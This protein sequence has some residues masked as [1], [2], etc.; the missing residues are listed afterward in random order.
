MLLEASLSF[1]GLGVQ[2][3]TASLGRMVGDNRNDLAMAWWTALSPVILILIV[4]LM[5]Q[6]I[7]DWLRDVF[8]VRLREG[9]RK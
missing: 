3:P 7:G 8:D 1:L 5:I 4:T 6:L 2:P 9:R